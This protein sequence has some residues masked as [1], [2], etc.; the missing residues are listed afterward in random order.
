MELLRIRPSVLLAFATSAAV[1]GRALPPLGPAQARAERAVRLL[2]PLAF[3]E[4]R[5]QWSPE[6]R[7]GAEAAGAAVRLDP[8]ALALRLRGAG[9]DG[10]IR[11]FALRLSFEGAR[12]NAVLEGEERLD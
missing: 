2:P 3:V 4:N 11:E 10:G 9:T 12:R 5:G 1:S 8:G 6:A 7:F